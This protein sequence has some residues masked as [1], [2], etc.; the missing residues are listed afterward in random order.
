MLGQ[1]LQDTAI[2]GTREYAASRVPF[3]AAVTRDHLKSD[4]SLFSTSD[5]FT[6]SV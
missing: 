6:G 4:L 3:R 2:V 5:R 1:F